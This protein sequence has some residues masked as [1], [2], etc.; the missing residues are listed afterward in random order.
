M[1]AVRWHWRA[2][3]D[4]KAISDTSHAAAVDAAVQR[5][6]ATGQG[7]V[8][9]VRESGSDDATRALGTRLIGIGDA[10]LLAVLLPRLDAPARRGLMAIVLSR[11]AA[12][13]G[14]LDVV[15][16][17][18]W[19]AFDRRELMSSTLYVSHRAAI[20][21]R[22]DAPPLQ[23]LGLFGCLATAE[24][25]EAMMADLTAAGLGPGD[26]SLALLRLNA[27]LAQ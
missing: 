7:F 10:E 26:P 2:V 13:P 3:D 20:A 23:I 5:L 25:A 11:E 27:A 22:T 17:D 18:A 24:A 1:K 16:D 8:R 6:A 15:P 12:T 21:D 9:I 19:C 14:P 4:L